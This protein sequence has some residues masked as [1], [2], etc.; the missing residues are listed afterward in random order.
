[1]PELRVRAVLYLALYNLLF[2]LPLIVVFIMAYYGTTSKDLTRFLQRNA[3][4]VKLGMVLLFAS[5][6]V[7][8]G[9][10]LI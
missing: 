6:A 2:V 4:V 1:V 8:L 10:T 3:A 5:L 9:F 7:W